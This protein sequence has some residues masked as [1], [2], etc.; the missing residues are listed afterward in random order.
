MEERNSSVPAEG[1]GQGGSPRL[2]IVDDEA[3]QMHALCNTLSAEGYRTRGFTS[4]QLALDS[5]REESFE[6]LLTDLMMPGIDGIALLAA[7]K[8]LD[9]DIVGIVMTGHG[10]IDTAVRAMQAGALDYIQK[11]FRLKAILPV[12]KRGLEIRRLRAE[13]TELRQA[14]ATISRLNEEL[15]QRVRERTHE[16]SRANQELAAA[17]QDLESFSFSVSHD[18]R[19]PLRAVRGFCQLYLDEY[20]GSIPAQGRP[21]LDRVAQGSERMSQLIEDLLSFARF[22][23]Q[24]LQKRRLSLRPIL[25]RVIAELQGKQVRPAEVRIGELPECE[26]DEALMEQ[27]LVN[28]LSN[29]FKFTRDRNPAVIEVGSRREGGQVIYFVRDNGAGFD[30]KYAGKL[31]G[32][33]Q[34]MHSTEEF[35]GTGVGLSIVHRVIGRHGGRIWAEAAPGQGATFLF[36]LAPP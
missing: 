2:L 23:R 33:F 27:V 32:V 5:L 19:A 30:M 1:A 8:T 35:E 31:F 22:S 25:E 3:A 11:P 14:Q 17:N 26:G 16:L 36:T 34:R 7:A 15:E 6:L 9:P 10:T 29:A 18:L 21:L 4:P 12:L 20:G 24:P 28:L 13:N